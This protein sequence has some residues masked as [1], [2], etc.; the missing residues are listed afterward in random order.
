MT[1]ERETTRGHH[2]RDESGR[3]LPGAS[4]NPAGRPKGARH[5]TTVAVEALLDGQA[6]ALTQ[7]AIDAA[8]GG[9]IPA[10]RL[11]LER[12]SPPRKDAPVA[13][14]LPNMKTAADAAEAMGAVVN[15][16]ADGSLTPTEGAAVAGLI[17]TFRRTLETT[18]L[19]ARIA[20]L[21]ARR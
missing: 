6:G 12:I 9:D 7:T 1:G 11:C 10:L 13:V 2:D 20:Q 8:L 18:E 14:N 4:G 15:Q 17:E 3:W 16:V 5:R 19:E 21:E